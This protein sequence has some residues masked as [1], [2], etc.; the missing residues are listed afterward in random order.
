MLLER[1]SKSVCTGQQESASLLFGL[2]C[3][4]AKMSDVSRAATA[5]LFGFASLLFTYIGDS[6]SAQ[7]KQYVNGLIE[8]LPT[9]KTLLLPVCRQLLYIISCIVTVRAVCVRI[10]LTYPQHFTTLVV[11]VRVGE[12]EQKQEGVHYCIS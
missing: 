9:H 12:I 6:S 5:S 1:T 2:L 8:Y 4:A 11:V 10:Q 7:V 3:C